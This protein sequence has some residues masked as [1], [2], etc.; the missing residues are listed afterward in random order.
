[1]LAAMA[2]PGFA[3]DVKTTVKVALLNVSSVMPTGLSG[4]GMMGPGMMGPGWGQGQ[5]QTYLGMM[6]MG[7]MGG[8]MTIRT[9]QSA[10]KAGSVTFDI[11][12]WSRSVLHE[13]LVVAVDNPA[14]P[15]PYDY[16]QARVPEE[17]VKVLG[18]AADLQPNVTK[19]LEVT[20]APGSY[21]LICNL[22]GHYAAG[23]VTAITVT[24]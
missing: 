7:M 12:N 11:T 19:S 21:L 13:M 4:Y 23:M 15:L 22:P 18:E 9:D 6:G 3:A 24:P 8:M 1:M 16:P 20:L 5:G 14:S 2:S 17:Q 10:V